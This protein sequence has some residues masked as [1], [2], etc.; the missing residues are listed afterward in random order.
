[1]Y[2]LYNEHMGARQSSPLGASPFDGLGLPYDR[3]QAL[4]F[5]I[6]WYSIE[7]QAKAADHVCKS[8][9]SNSVFI[10]QQRVRLDTSGD[11]WNATSV[12]NMAYLAL[13]CSQ[14]HREFYK[15]AYE[16]MVH[17]LKDEHSGF[18]SDDFKARLA[19]C[20]IM[21]PRYL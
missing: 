20:D 14:E 13:H 11:D 21:Q 15:Q 18:Y 16:A 4:R 8:M 3:L 12:G 1:M 2:L 9:A 5:A 10:G 19:T 7:E 6:L 17:R